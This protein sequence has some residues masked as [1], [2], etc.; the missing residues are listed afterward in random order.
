MTRCS[1]CNVAVSSSE[2]VMRVK[3]LV[4]HIDCFTC[5]ACNERFVRG[6]EL[7]VVNDAIYCTTHYHELL[8]T[9]SSTSTSAAASVDDVTSSQHPYY[10]AAYSQTRRARKRSGKPHT[11]D[12]QALGNDTLSIDQ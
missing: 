5:H 1:K 11:T 2:L 10:S 8:A 9:S 3:E 12:A 7:A 4:F 6:Q